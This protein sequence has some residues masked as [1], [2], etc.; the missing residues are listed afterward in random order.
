MFSLTSQFEVVAYKTKAV[1]HLTL[2]QAHKRKLILTRWIAKIY[3]WTRDYEK[4][5]KRYILPGPGRYWGLG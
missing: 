1:A 2:C 4:G 3:L 5:Y